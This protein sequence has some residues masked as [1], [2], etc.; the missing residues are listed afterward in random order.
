[1]GDGSE[2]FPH[3]EVPPPLRAAVPRRLL[4]FRAGRFCAL[5][6]MR[7]L[8]ARCSGRAIPRDNDGAPRWPRGFVGSITH[9]RGFVSAAV[10]HSHDAAGLGLDVEELMSARL[11]SD[12]LTMIARPSEMCSV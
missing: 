6:A 8:E 5:D 7:R 9:A 2:A 11:A 12:V 4:Q 3:V 1:M 10:A